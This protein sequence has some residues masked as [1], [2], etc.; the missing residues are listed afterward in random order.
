MKS[1]NNDKA[2]RISV[3]AVVAYP[4]LSVALVVAIAVALTP[5]GTSQVMALANATGSI[6]STAPI[7]GAI[8]TPTSTPTAGSTTTPDRTVIPGPTATP[9]A[10]TD[11]APLPDPTYPSSDV[12]VVVPDETLEPT[13]QSGPSYPLLAPGVVA[14]GTTPAT[15]LPGVNNPES[16]SAAVTEAP[17][18]IHGSYSMA[19]DKC[20]ICHRGHSAKASNLTKQS[21][22]QSALCYAC[23]N[24]LGAQSNVE[25]QFKD[26][27][28]PQNND[29]TRMYYRHD[30]V[31]AI[32]HSAGNSDEGDGSGAGSEF[33]GVSNRHSECV[34]CHNPHQANGTDGTTTATGVTASGRLAG[35]SGVSVVNGAAGTSPAYTLLDGKSPTTSITR[36]YQLCF[37]CHSGFTTLSSN[38]G[39]VPSRYRLDKGI[40]FNPNNP[41]FHP[42][43]AA[44]KNRSPKMIASLAGTSPYKI[45]NFNIDSTIR[46]VNCHASSTK[47][48]LVT[49]PSAN[50]DLP[51]HT[52]KNPGIL[53]QNYRNRLL[54]PQNQSYQ[55]ADFALCYMCH[56]NTPFKNETTTATNFGLHG[57]HLT[58]LTGE[59]SANTLIDQP[60]AGGGNAICAECHF[61][62][63][64]TSFKDTTAPQTIPGSRLVSFAPNVTGQRKWA[65]GT[66]L[67]QGSCTLTCHGK[68]HSGDGYTD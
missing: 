45:W 36:E 8:A 55:D 54:K 39:F 65:P 57:K 60:G 16:V 23:H 7:S 11:A 30:T 31:G 41:S 28:V 12:T 44:G 15:A 32:A 20:A 14:A 61:R 42:V 64:S 49:P 35:A 38:A 6:E 43:E 52:S 48:N 62:Q 34:D 29:T 33:R 68:S 53:L 63:H 56:S 17:S 2:R 66:T 9:G 21:G 19:T 37:K 22:S 18:S 4:A 10:T 1:L 5:F 26:P 3:R 46:C 13:G 59:G 51:M 50:G 67:G 58:R 27:L 24:G 25:A 40:E 47:Y